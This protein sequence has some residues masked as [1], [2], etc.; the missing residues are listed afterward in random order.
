MVLQVSKWPKGQMRY[1]S[2]T[3]DHP[4][5]AFS[6]LAIWRFA[7]LAICRKA[8]VRIGP[9]D[10]RLRPA[11]HIPRIRPAP[12]R[13]TPHKRHSPRRSSARRAASSVAG[14]WRRLCDDT[15]GYVHVKIRRP[16]GCT[17]PQSHT[18][19]SSHSM[20]YLRRNARTSSLNS[21]VLWCSFWL[22]MYARSASTPDSPIENP[23]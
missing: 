21:T 17:W 5:H 2:R 3:T 15:P 6:D 1:R 7:D 12:R 22:A 8:V 18:Y 10:P 19:R 16:K 9:R 23:K 14:V 4:P 20:P 11:R 13:H